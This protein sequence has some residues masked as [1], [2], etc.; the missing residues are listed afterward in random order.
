MITSLSNI[1]TDT[2]IRVEEK[3]NWRKWKGPAQ[4]EDTKTKSL[5]ML[6]YVPPARPSPFVVLLLTSFRTDMALIKDKSFKQ[7]ALKYAKS[8]DEFFKE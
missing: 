7:Y 1:C 8:E 6:P 5:M 2:L 4:Y 3:W